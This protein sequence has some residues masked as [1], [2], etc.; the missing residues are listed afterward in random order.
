LADLVEQS[1]AFAASLASKAPLALYACVEAVQAAA[2]TSA[3]EGM[4]VEASVF[5]RT[6]GTQDFKEGTMAFLEKRTANFTGR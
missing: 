2:D 1:E 3:L 5:G 4:Y 6:C